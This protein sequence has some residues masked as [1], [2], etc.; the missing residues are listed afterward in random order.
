MTQVFESNENDYRYTTTWLNSTKGFRVFYKFADIVDQTKPWH[1][2][3]PLIR[4]S[5]MYYILAETETDPDVALDYLNT[6]RYN[7]GLPDLVSGSDIISEI[8]K[9]YQKEFWGEGQLFFYYK[10]NN[11]TDVPVG[12]SGYTWNTTTPVYMVPLPL[13]ETT[14]R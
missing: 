6:V 11:I 2:L 4:K 9:E 7:R 1:F 10:R 3:Q 12:T 13:S 5:E 8:R 14:P